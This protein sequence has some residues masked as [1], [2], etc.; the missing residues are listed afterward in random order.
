MRSRRAEIDAVDAAVDV[1]RLREAT[2]A[3][4]EIVETIRAATALHF[5][6]AFERLQCTNQDAAADPGQLPR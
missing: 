6:D 2:G 4:G 1:Q 3:A 5:G